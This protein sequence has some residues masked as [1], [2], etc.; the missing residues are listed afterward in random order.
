MRAKGN[1]TL[2][3]ISNLK[4]ENYCLNFDT[5]SLSQYF[6]GTPFTE[7]IAAC[8]FSSTVYGH[9]DIKHLRIAFLQQD[10]GSVKLAG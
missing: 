1:I 7:I 3:M 2:K 4:L 10:S 6:M 5:A 9:P 8:I